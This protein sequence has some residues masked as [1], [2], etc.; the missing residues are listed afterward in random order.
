MCDRGF[1]CYVY[2]RNERGL[3]QHNTAAHSLFAAAMNAIRWFNE[4]HG[5]RPTPET[6]LRV[7]AGWYGDQKEYSV[8]ADRVV[9]H[10]GLDP[11]NWL[12]A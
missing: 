4:W 7:T 12:D 8:R 5:P 9:E 2:F 11:K 1:P 10:F 3:W 6:V